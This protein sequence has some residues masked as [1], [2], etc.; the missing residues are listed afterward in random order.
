MSPLWRDEV[1]AYLS[2]H[3]LCLVRM[4]RGVQPRL[5]AE[6]ERRFEN[7]KDESW[8]GPVEALGAL[9]AQEPWRASRIHIVL[10]DHWA[11]YAIVPWVAA[12]SSSEERIAH[13]RQ[14]L[15][16]MYGEAVSGWEVR[17]SEAPPRAPRVACAISGEL[18]AAVR[19]VCLAQGCRV[20]SL[21][22]QL[23]ASYA[24]W[25]HAL[26]LAN[27]WFV[28]IEQGSMAA[29]RVARHGWD[30]VHAVRIGTDWT[31]E[32][33]RLQTFGRLASQVPEEGKVYVEAP[34]A[35]REIAAAAA[36]NTEPG[37]LQWLE[38]AGTEL[39]TLQRL[40]RTRRMAA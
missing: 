7:V 20:L 36:G 25:R 24:A 10:A 4:Q 34:Q 39:T 40:A 6:H 1:G 2:P 33:K 28:S 16:S 35:W 21:Q 37:G 27:A 38:D 30:R 11:R 8:S 13:G 9:L 19:S 29:A 14:L 31:R 18:I 26:P 17:I 3:H 15:G 32:L 23:V 12:L 22:S 5:A